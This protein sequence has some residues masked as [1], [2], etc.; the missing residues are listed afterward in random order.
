MVRVL[1]KEKARTLRA[2]GKTYTEIKQA[3]GVSKGTLSAW[4]A[5]MPLS[6]EQ[7]RQ[8]RDLNP[9]RIE[10]FRETMKAKRMARLRNAYDKARI[11]IGVLSERDLFIAGLYLYWGEGTKAARGKIA[12]TNTNPAMI[13]TFLE[14]SRNLGFSLQDARVRLHLYADMEVEKEIKFWSHELHV[15]VRQ[16]RKPYVKKSMLSDITYKNGFGHG[17]CSVEFDNVAT[18][19]YITMAL[20][21]LGEQCTRP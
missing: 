13:R 10:T 11:D 17:T 7:I 18:W 1:D 9:R 15:P 2:A 8:V 6:A 20:K 5:D 21:Y 16:F 19:E 12:L 3:L 4:L 14:W